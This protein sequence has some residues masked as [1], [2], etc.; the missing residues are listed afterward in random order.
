MSAHRTGPK[1]SVA[2]AP[3]SG[4]RAQR[5]TPPG[6]L[7]PEAWP[8]IQEARA[9]YDAGRS[10]THERVEARLRARQTARRAFSGR[11]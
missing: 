2:G 4:D 3:E 10:Y 1:A 9:Q 8:A 7:L 11:R 5:K 6:D